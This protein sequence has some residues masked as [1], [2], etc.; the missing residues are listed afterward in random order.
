MPEQLRPEGTT[1]AVNPETPRSSGR[2]GVLTGV[3]SAA[4]T[5][6]P[7]SLPHRALARRRLDRA[8]AV[9]RRHGLSLPPEARAVFP[10]A[11]RDERATAMIRKALE[12]AARGLFRRIGPLGVLAAAARGLE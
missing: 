2:L 9:L 1:A 12:L 5:A 11:G 3:A 4:A 7:P 10:A 6:P 8:P